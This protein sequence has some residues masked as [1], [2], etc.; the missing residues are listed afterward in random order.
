VRTGWTVGKLI[1][2]VPVLIWMGLIFYLSAQPDLPHHPEGVID[3]IMKKVGHMGKYG[4]LAALVWWAWPKDA[5]ESS[6]RVFPY[7]L[8]LSGLYAFSDE[9]HQLFVPGRDGQLLDLAFDLSGAALALFLISKLM[10]RKHT[11]QSR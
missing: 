4:I 3:L 9:V 11:P 6:G 5:R 7:A 1:R 10:G 2:W 8:I